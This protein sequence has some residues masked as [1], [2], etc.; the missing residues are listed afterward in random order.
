MGLLLLRENRAEDA[1]MLF[2]AGLLADPYYG[3]LFYNYVQALIQ[4]R[5]FQE[6]DEQL[7]KNS[8]H[9]ED[10]NYHHVYALLYKEK[11]HYRRALESI[12]KAIDLNPFLADYYITRSKIYYAMG[13]LEAAARDLNKVSE[14]AR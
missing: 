1:L 8:D 3:Q 2:R 10:P 6:A 4:L 11:G 9:M 7:K 13:D 5:R 12:N 14:I